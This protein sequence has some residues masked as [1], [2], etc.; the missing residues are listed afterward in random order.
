MMSS[1][2][3]LE[4]QN[5]LYY[6]FELDNI[7]YKESKVIQSFLNNEFLLFQSSLR[8][9]MYN[10]HGFHSIG[11]IQINNNTQIYLNTQD[12]YLF[13]FNTQI[14]VYE[15]KIPQIQINLTDQQV[16]GITYDIT[17]YAK[18]YNLTFAGICKIFMSI[19]I[20]D[21]NDT[22]IYVMFNKN[23]PQ[24]RSIKGNEINEQIFVGYSGKLLQYTVNTDNK[25]FGQ[26]HQTTYQE[27]L[28]QINQKF[29]L[30]QLSYCVCNDCQN[31]QYQEQLFFIGVTNEQLQITKFIAHSDY[32]VNFTNI[33]ITIQAKQL[34]A[35]CNDDGNLIIGVSDNDT[36]QLYQIY[37]FQDKPYFLSLEFKFEQQFQQFL[38][39]YNNLIT[40]F[41]NEEI[42]IMTLNFTNLVIINETMINKLFKSD[43]QL[44]FNP[45]QIAVNTQSLSSCL[46]INN[47]NNVIIIS[48]GESNMPIPISIIDFK[49]QIKQ[50]NIVNQQLVL[51]YICNQGF[52][53]CFQV[54]SIQNLKQPFFMRNMTSLHNINY[55]QILS[56]KLFYYVQFSNFTVYVYN[57]YLPQHMSLYYQLILSS[58]LIC[59]VQ[60]YYEF[61]F[62]SSIG[63]ILYIENFFNQLSREQSFQ[64]LVNQSLNF[65]R[66]YPQMIYNYTVTSLLNVTANQS[67]PNQSLTYLSN[68]TYFQPK[69]KI[70]KDLL[71][72][73]LN[74]N[75]R[76]LTY[77]MNIILDRQASLCYF[78]K[79]SD[80]DKVQ[81]VDN[82]DQSDQQYFTNDECNLTNFGYF[83]KNIDLNYTQV[84][85]V[86]NK[87]FILQNNSVIRI[88]NQYFEFLQSY[89]YSN[90][91]F[92]ECLKSTSY[93]LSLS[94]ICQ[95]DTAQYWLTIYFDSNG[96]VINTCLLQIPY[97]FTYIKKISNIAF[98]NFI[99]GSYNQHSQH[100]YLLNPFNNSIQLISS[101]CQD[102]SVSLYNSSLDMNQSFLVIILYISQNRVYCQQLNFIK[103]LI[104]SGQFAFFK[105]LHNIPLVQILILQIRDKQ[106]FFLITSIEGVG[107]LLVYKLFSKLYELHPS[108][109]ITTIT[110][111]THNNTVLVPNSVYSNGFLLQ[112]F[113]QGNTYI[114]G[115]YYIPDLLINNLEEPILML[116]QLNSKSP[117]YA[118][119]TNIEDRNSTCLALNNGSVLYYPIYTRT[120]KCH[121]RE[122]R[123]TVNV[124]IVCQN[125][126][127]NGSYEITFILP[128]LDEPS[129]RWIYSLITIIIFQLIGFYILVKYRMRNIGYINTE[130]EL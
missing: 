25:Q 111:Y 107:Y 20:L 63:S 5:N 58:K 22:N 81:K 116:G 114:I 78:P 60:L 96:S 101:D 11:N 54:W 17:I 39:T 16:Q 109:F 87:F 42:Q 33:T 12:N 77:P 126:F 123:N 80:V 48:I 8:L 2:K 97:K 105:F 41:V 29:T 36:I 76:T 100:F 68:F 26:F 113:K 110:A 7:D 74:L 44:K 120:L 121:Y 72:K 38:V 21:Q 73:D 124:N 67:T 119:I 53:L 89:D 37:P 61:D 57:P 75:D 127:S 91:N 130:I 66:S 86:N 14:I 32:Q 18:L 106:I 64:L 90:L 46:F 82:V 27:R 3:Y 84:T 43:S 50:I 125:D 98:L 35:S 13:T 108:N 117:E 118:L 83:T 55:L 1:S 59:T 19:T 23:F 15:L 129:R 45:I 69:T 9:I 51:S 62:K 24:Y 70:I 103:Y 104:T 34:Q 95:N 49:F 122:D 10:L 47:I 85:A 30:A 28:L 94:S 115:V 128:K 88:V 4:C 102:F 65:S 99:L 40:L 79:S 71:I 52:D 56:D 112:Q 92:T 93:N 6:Q 31:D